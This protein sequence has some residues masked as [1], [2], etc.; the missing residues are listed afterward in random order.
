MS[1]SL[2]LQRFLAQCGVTS[3]R[4]AE[5]LIVD[6][7]VTV[8]GKRCTELG[9]C[10]DPNEDAVAL[11]GVA[12]V[13]RDRVL[14]ALHKPRG[15]VST[16]KDP[17][18]R[19]DLSTAADRAG[20]RL[21]PIGRLD[22]D[23]G[24]LLLLTNDGEYSNQ[25]LHP[26]FAIPRTYVARVQGECGPETIA[27][28]LK[29]CRL[30]DGFGLADKAELL[31]I[32]EAALAYGF[33]KKTG[34]SRFVRIIVHEGRNHFVKRLLAAVGLTVEELYRVAF[35]PYRLGKLRP[36]EMKQLRFEVLPTARVKPDSATVRR[37]PRASTRARTNPV[38]KAPSKVGGR[39][40]AKS[41]QPGKASKKQ[42]RSRRA[43]E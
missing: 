7:R 12:V 18:G 14:Y 20:Q 28:L 43:K 34:R 13:I 35:G 15:V 10:V 21:Y 37:K 42:P 3:R 31:S 26:R 11:D 25:M 41:R 6:G 17:E 2:R 23:V 39:S 16:L 36:G 9:T 40:S 1:R 5:Q 24:G 32:E 29:G 30:S 8:N 22:A 33:W 38:K 27:Q 4:N 19:P